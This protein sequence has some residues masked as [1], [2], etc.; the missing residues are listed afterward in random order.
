[1]KHSPNLWSHIVIDIELGTYLT[2]AML[3]MI[4]LHLTRS[5]SV[6]IHV[7]I[8]YQRSSVS[9]FALRSVLSPSQT[10]LPERHRLLRLAAL[11]LPHTSRF[12][13]FH[14]RMRVTPVIAKAFFPL[15]GPLKVL[16]DL[17]VIMDI[18]D[19]GFGDV[20]DISLVEEGSECS[21]DALSLLEDNGLFSPTHLDAARLKHIDHS[22]SSAAM[23]K[24]PISLYLPRKWPSSGGA[25]Y[26][27]NID[28]PLGETGLPRDR[29][30]PSERVIVV[31]GCASPATPCDT[32]LKISGG[33]AIAHI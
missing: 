11:L 6:P 30:Y 4:Q 31:I 23:R 1:M 15:P 18:P 17:A 27:S 16:R 21:P 32:P 14:C 28:N 2:E 10:S 33:H 29:T 25:K 22:L 9:Q 20:D 24:A 5:K 8:S 26:S 12:Q 7:R 13:T 19:R 3:E